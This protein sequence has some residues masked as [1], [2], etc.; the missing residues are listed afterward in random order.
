MVPE[1]PEYNKNPQILYS[2]I[3]SLDLYLTFVGKMV[4]YATF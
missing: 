2:L 1:Y 4:L 3:D